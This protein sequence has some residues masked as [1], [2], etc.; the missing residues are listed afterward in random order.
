M[1]SQM[2][3]YICICI[4][5]ALEEP[6]RGQLYQAPVSKHFL[7]SAIVSKFG[8][9]RWD[10][11]LGGAVSRWPSLQHLLR[12]LSLHFPST[13]R[14]LTFQMLPLSWSPLSKFFTS[15]LLLFDSER[16][17]PHSSIHSPSPHVHQHP[18]SLGH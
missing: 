10:G 1:L 14:I 12:S 8:V 17:P 5:P 18:P 4:G 15:S 13:G 16:A 2:A 9:S 6:L 7:A 3:V 11:S